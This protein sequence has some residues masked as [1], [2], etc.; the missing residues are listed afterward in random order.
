MLKMPLKIN[1]IFHLHIY[2]VVI[3]DWKATQT[4]ESIGGKIVAFNRILSGKFEIWC[5][6]V[7]VIQTIEYRYY[8]L[9]IDRILTL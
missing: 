4:L 5:V 8:L 1:K 2:I 9:N 3:K 7:I 6:G